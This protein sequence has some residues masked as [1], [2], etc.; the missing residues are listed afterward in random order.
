MP[1]GHVKSDKEAFERIQGRLE[2]DI[3]SILKLI[4]DETAKHSRTNGTPYWALVRMMFPVAEAGRFDL[5]IQVHQPK[6]DLGA[7]K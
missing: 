4:K 2:N 7:R 1:P 6:P 5:S 3:G